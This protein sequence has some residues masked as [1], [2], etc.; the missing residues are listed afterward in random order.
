MKHKFLTRTVGELVVDNPR[1]ARLFEAVGNDYCRGGNAPLESACRER[2]L[3]AENTGLGE[4]SEMRRF[5]R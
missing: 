5:S 3:D 2:G 4:R 1:F